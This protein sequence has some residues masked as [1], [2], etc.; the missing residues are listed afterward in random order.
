MSSINGDKSRFHRERKQKIRRRL[1]NHK[2]LESLAIQPKN[3]TMTAPISKP[4]G[5]AHD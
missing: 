2:L 4:K 3:T 1:R 5:A